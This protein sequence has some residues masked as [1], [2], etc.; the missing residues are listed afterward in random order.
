MRKD[1]E[2][3]ISPLLFILLLG[4]IL[5]SCNEEAT[6]FGYDLMPS[7]DVV[8]K[9]YRTYGVPTESYAVEDSVLARTSMSYLGRYTDPETGTSIKGDFISQY[10]INENVSLFPDV[11]TNDAI[12]GMDVRL[13][14]DKFIGD[15]L[16]TFKISVYDLN[17]NLDAEA[18]YYTNLDPTKYYD[19]EAEPLTTK[20]YTLSDQTLTD[21]ERTASGYLRNIRISLPKEIGQHIYDAY[22][23]DRSKFSSTYNWLNSGLPCSK[24]LYY[25]LDYGDGAMAYISITQMN[26]YFNYYDSEYAHDTTGV[27]RLT[28]TEEVIEATSF[29][30]SNLEP[31]IQDGTCTYIKSPAGIFTMA[32]L[33]ID[34]I[35][36]NDT[37]NSA[38]LVFTRYND[39]PQKASSFKPS[40]PKTLLLVRY[41]DYKNGYFEKYSKADSNTSYLT[42]YSSNGNSYTFANI[43][44]LISTCLQEKKN[45]TNSENY[46]KV[47]LIP[48]E[49]TY[50]TSNNLVKLNHDFSVSSAKLVKG[51]TTDGPNRNEDDSSNILL[52]VT[53]SSFDK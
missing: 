17:K 7:S 24:G 27:T 43:A 50:D 41:D 9:S 11:I 20:W 48:V 16:T 14:V 1:F 30:N 47:L 35:N 28:S 53:Y 34:S 36:V 2:K 40:I 21:S 42:S 13:Y 4:T 52:K 39:D 3:A 46:N 26:I 15:S 12:T 18:D 45:G 19:E 25:K 23:A 49:A 33:P 29:D 22:K 31:L 32:T 10:H 44:R 51:F 38:S 5:V 6:S 8:T 37:I